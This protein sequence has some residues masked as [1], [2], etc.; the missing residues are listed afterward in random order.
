MQNYKFEKRGQK[1][2]L[3]WRSP[4]SRRSSAFDCSDIEKEEIILFL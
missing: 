1:T 3:K 2:D 4:L